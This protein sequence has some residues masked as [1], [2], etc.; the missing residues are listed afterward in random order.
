MT[1]WQLNYH[2]DAHP[3]VRRCIVPPA[4]TFL[5]MTRQMAQQAQHCSNGRRP[6]HRQS[7]F[8]LIE[9]EKS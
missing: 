2:L 9:G 3:C 1:G 4:A 8:N 5:L 7:P 6:N